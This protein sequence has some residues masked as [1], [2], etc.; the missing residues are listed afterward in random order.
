M[1]IVRSRAIEDIYDKK[2]Q[3]MIVGKREMRA[4]KYTNKRVKIH[5]SDVTSLCML[6]P[7]YHRVLDNPPLPSFNSSWSF[8]RGR[9]VERSIALE[10]AP[11][12]VDGIIGT[13]DDILDGEI[14]E[15]KSTAQG[16]EFFNPGKEQ[17]EWISRMKGYCYM[18]GKTQM[19]LFVVFIVGNLPNY[20]WW[21]VKKYGKRPKKYQGF[22]TRAWKVSFDSKELEGFWAETIETKHLLEKAVSD[23]TP[24]ILFDIVK[25]NKPEWICKPELCQYYDKCEYRNQ[26]KV[27]DDYF[28]EVGL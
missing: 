17:P 19:Y 6:Q 13:V 26:G 27:S 24:E 11:V 21:S 25:A 1:E 22:A 7:Y 16:S 10:L 5:L 23:K 15:I 9:V 12:T 4:V 18:Y 3:D 14:V 2:I 8:L 20:M 28:E